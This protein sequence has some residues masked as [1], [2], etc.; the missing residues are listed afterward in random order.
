[1][2]GVKADI[3]V[4][5]DGFITGPSVGPGNGLGDDGERLHEW[6]YYL[7]SFRAMH[8]QEGGERT[9]D[10]EILAEAFAG[11][12]AIVMGRGMFDASEEA[13]GPEPPFE[14]PVF[15]MTHERRDPLVKGATTFTFVDDDASVERKKLLATAPCRSLAAG[16]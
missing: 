9:R 14:M 12:G 10:T 4:S 5:I 15:V 2:S 8:H 7:E 16:R 3:S 13:W 1:M 11:V 6:L